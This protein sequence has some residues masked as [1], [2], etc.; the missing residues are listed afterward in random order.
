MKAIYALMLAAAAV[1][2]SAPGQAGAT[3]CTIRGT[4]GK[5]RLVGTPGADVIC[6]GGGVDRIA[7]R[8]GDDVIRGGADRDVIRAGRGSDR[9]W[10]GKG[11]DQILAGGL[12][13]GENVLVVVRVPTTFTTVRGGI[14]SSVGAGRT[15]FAAISAEP[16]WLAEVPDPTDAYGPPTGRGTT[17]WWADPAQTLSGPTSGT[18]AGRWKGSVIAR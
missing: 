2:L 7:G 3:R 14:G 5:D 9:V 18:L 8:G 16:T 11:G 13:D 12:P 10:G 17:A 6:G 4:P 1:M 15:G